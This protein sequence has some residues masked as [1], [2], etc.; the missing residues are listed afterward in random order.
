[1]Q[2]FVNI[3]CEK[4]CVRLFWRP[5]DIRRL[6]QFAMLAGSAQAVLHHQKWLVGIL[7]SSTPANG[8]A[9]QVAGGQSEAGKGSVMSAVCAQ[10]SSTAGAATDAS[11]Y[12]LPYTG[13]TFLQDTRSF[14]HTLTGMLFRS[15][16]SS[17]WF[18]DSSVCNICVG[19]K[20]ENYMVSW[21]L[22]SMN[23]IFYQKWNEKHW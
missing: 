13:F 8:R 9:D 7:W 2:L 18:I 22:E 21:V 16:L 11:S 12:C 1:M 15:N 20:G 19:Y 10:F 4:F 5:S 6:L 14:Q 17:P 3:F 23:F